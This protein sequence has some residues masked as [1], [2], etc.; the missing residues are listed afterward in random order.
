MLLN[1]CGRSSAGTDCAI[2]RHKQDSGHTAT[3]AK[4]LVVCSVRS[5]RL[6]MESGHRPA[7][8][9]FASVAGNAG[10]VRKTTRP[11]DHTRPATSGNSRLPARRP[12]PTPAPDACPPV[13]PACGVACLRLRPVCDRRILAVRRPRAA[14]RAHPAWGDGAAL[15]WPDEGPIPRTMEEDQCHSTEA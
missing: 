11:R 12:R 8:S 4:Q 3:Q 7:T 1:F 5:P 14:K 6:L 2:P 9:S 10:C 13:S 15:R